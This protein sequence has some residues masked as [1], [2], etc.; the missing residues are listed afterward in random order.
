MQL[1]NA[2]LQLYRDQPGHFD[3]KFALATLQTPTLQRQDLRILVV[4]WRHHHVGAGPPLRQD[5][6][7]R[8][9]GVARESTR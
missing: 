9:D 4:D 2:C 7:T 1:S 3:T 8:F 5:I 6:N